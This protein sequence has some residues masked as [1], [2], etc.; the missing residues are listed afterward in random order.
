MPATKKGRQRRAC[1]ACV[2]SHAAPVPLRILSKG[3]GCPLLARGE[4][5]NGAAVRGGGSGGWTD[6]GKKSGYFS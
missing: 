5:G 6:D 2:T 3:E 1:V 4:V